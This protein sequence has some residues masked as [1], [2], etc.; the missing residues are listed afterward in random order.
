[1]RRWWLETFAAWLVGTVLVV[2]Y[3]MI[4]EAVATRDLG[5]MP[6]HW[7]PIVDFIYLN[8]WAAAMIVFLVAELPAIL[9]RR[10]GG[11]LASTWAIAVIVLLA[12]LAIRLIPHGYPEDGY[13]PIIVVAALIAGT[14]A[15]LLIVLVVK[16]MAQEV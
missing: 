5:W 14:I 3:G 1:M 11:S 6:T 15:S 12:V 10:R 7:S 2:G 4:T 16:P 13:I 8:G 9:W